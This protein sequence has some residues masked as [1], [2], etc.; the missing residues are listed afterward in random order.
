LCDI[1]TVGSK[2]RSSLTETGLVDLYQ[3]TM[4]LAS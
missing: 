3:V 1:L 2:T 4:G